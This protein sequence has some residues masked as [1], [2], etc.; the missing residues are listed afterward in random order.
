MMTFSEEGSF[1]HLDI[2]S[3]L[4]GQ[5]KGGFNDTIQGGGGGVNR[6]SC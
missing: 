5:D 3:G 2:W 4:H 1:N 6:N